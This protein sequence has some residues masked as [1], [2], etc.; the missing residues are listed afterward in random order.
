MATGPFAPALPFLDVDP[1]TGEASITGYRCNRCEV[2]LVGRRAACSACC[3]RGSLEPFALRTTGRLQNYTIVHRS[4]PGVKT[5][6]VAAVVDLDGGGVLK[7]TLRDANPAPA[8]LKP[9]TAIEVLF[10]DSGQR[11]QKGRVLI[12]YHFERMGA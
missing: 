3:A 5:P 8:H 12:C 1:D 11:D 6:F 10:G 2:A 4:F 7:G 9:G